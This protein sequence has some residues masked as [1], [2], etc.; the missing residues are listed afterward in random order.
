MSIRRISR[1][2]TFFLLLCAS[3]LATAQAPVFTSSPPPAG[4]FG[5][6][7]SFTLTA[8]G[9]PPPTYSVLPN[10]YVLPPGLTLNGTSGLISGTPSYAGT[11]TGQFR[12]SNG[13]G[14]GA[15]QSFSIVIAPNQTISFGPL[16]D[17]ASGSPTFTVSA[18]ASSGLPVSF[19]ATTSTCG[20]FVGTN[21]VALFAGGVCTIRA[22]QAGNA[23]FSAATPVL[24]SFLITT[25]MPLAQTITFGPLTDRVLGG[26]S[27][28]VS[29]TATSLL[30]VAF[31]SLTAPVCTLSGNTV[32]LVSAGICSI[33]ASQAGNATFASAPDV[34]RSFG[35]TQTT[36]S[37]A[38]GAL[39]NRAIGSAP[40][41]VSATATSGLAVSF[42]SQSPTVCTVSGST[43][44][45]V[46]AGTCTIR[47]SQAGNATYAAAAIVDQ[48]FSVGQAGQT[49]TFSA[50]GNKMLGATPFVV[51]AAASS[52]LAV[53][54]ASLTSA[55]CTVNG[56][57]VTLVAAGTCT[58]RASQTGD[59]NFYAAP[60][61][62]QSFAVRTAQTISFEVLSNR[63]LGT[64]P[65]TVGA[66]ASSGLPVSFSSQTTNVCT[67][68]GSTVTLVTTGDCTLRANQAGDATYA[69]APNVDQS[70][71]VTVLR[72]LYDNAGNLIGTRR[73]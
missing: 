50:L 29:A 57:N 37:I 59:A 71:S 2:G 13:L 63:Q 18:T 5:V 33:R 24:Q 35:V 15:Y 61:V 16:P 45:L 19:N 72:Y 4:T 17:R 58:V 38:F 25:G 68:S 31:V 41:A 69:P 42:S 7:Y 36:Q 49:I 65:F 53:T 56:N 8:A 48:S 62:D 23:N 54:F 67:V 34:E 60:N 73:Y 40:F 55:V 21:T 11:F 28:T 3:V 52:G 10:S 43:V 12:A 9:G 64:P 51:S 22:A 46:A 66:T 44:T 14:L 39:G 27:F 30:P 70:F 32:T 47:A 20:V 1:F 6:P 26:S